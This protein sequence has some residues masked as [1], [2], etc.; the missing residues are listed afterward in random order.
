MP[1]VR[2]HGTK[3][4]LDMVAVLEDFPRI[5][6][7]LNLVPSL[8]D[9]LEEYL[10]PAYR[11]DAFLDASRK[12]AAE[13]SEQ[14]QRFVLEHFFM[15]NFD[16]MIRPYPRFHDLWVKRG[17]TVNET[18][19]PAVTKRF[20]P[21][22]LLD[23]QVWF[24]LA[25]IDPWLRRR[26]A[27]LTRLEQKGGHYT[28]A[29]KGVVLAAQLRILGEV[30]PA[31]RGAQDRG[32]V[33]LTCSPYYHPILPLLCD[34]RAAQPGLPHSPL[35]AVSFRHPDDATWHIHR[36]MESHAERFGRRP[37]G[38]WPS[39]GS[40]S[41]DV[42]RLAIEQGIRWIATDEEILWRTLKISPDPALRYRP[43][44]LRRPEGELAMVFRDHELSDL[45]GFVYSQWE[46]QAAVQDFLRR[47]GQIHQRMQGSAVPP[48]VSII[49]DGEN[50]WEFYPDDGR[51]FFLGLYEAL[52][53]DARFRA[54]TVTEYLQANAL[55]D[56]PSLPTLF[57]GSWIDGNF[58][59]W[60]GHPEKNTAWSHLARVR[61]MLA[62][63]PAP[64]AGSPEAE[65]H[66]H[67]WRSFYAAEGSDWTW[68]LGDTHSS[69]QDDEF[70]RLFRTHLANVFLFL[71]QEPPEWLAV[72]IK[73]RAVRPAY[74]PT[75]PMTPTIDGLETTYYEWL[76]AGRMDLRK[77]YAAIHRGRQIL[78]AV[79]YGYDR[80]YW[81][82]RLDVDVA[83]LQQL[84]NWRI[85]LDL[86]EQRAA[87][88]VEP[89]AGGVQSTLEGEQSVALACAFQRTIELA[90]PYKPL[91][92]GAGHSF[93]LRVELCDGDDVVERYPS[94]GAFRV[95]IPS[96][97]LEGAMWSV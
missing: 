48:L 9:Q 47:L 29:E 61:D 28:E 68:W 10:A 66:A 70:D 36:A 91:G 67:A 96:A 46:P 42:V 25:W 75:A 45:L 23:L 54:V 35:P 87:V 49:L 15:A 71:G 7:T 18:D 63:L 80:E 65:A 44:V 22:D 76:Y 90:L 2:L 62:A 89:T 59:T 73:T 31:Y 20:K 97:D 83:A 40:V 77:G 24:N 92:I 16:R 58:G 51:A 82:V 21:Q 55:T 39:E 13:L 37:T 52:E 14:E 38:M 72:A 11:S 4:Y 79:Y 41:E 53:R 94:Q 3:D 57:P 43:H 93:A 32:Q 5:H 27:A 74:E 26:D 56:T 17:A 84:T 34:L 64:A 78:L 6:Q 8:L 69:A 1:W 85:R 86:P 12:P 19:W 95:A 60:I 30:L 33:E 81:Y 88:V 50:A